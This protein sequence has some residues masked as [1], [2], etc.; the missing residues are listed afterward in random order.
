MILCGICV[1]NLNFFGKFGTLWQSRK[2][3]QGERDVG[4]PVGDTF[5]HHS[6]ITE[7]SFVWG[8]RAAFLKSFNREGP[9]K[10]LTVYSGHVYNSWYNSVVVTAKSVSYHCGHWEE[11]PPYRQLKRSLW[12]VGTYPRG[13]TCSLLKGHLATSGGTLESHG[14]PGWRRLFWSIFFWPEIKYEC[15][16]LFMFCKYFFVEVITLLIK[17]EIFFFFFYG[18]VSPGFRSRT[19]V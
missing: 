17:P 9:L 15:I 13:R 19:G 10:L 12:S 2:P 16:V 1:R 6:P 4:K 8:F 7:V 3:N 5:Y 14:T 11:S 18:Y